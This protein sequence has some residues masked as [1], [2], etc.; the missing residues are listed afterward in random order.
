MTACSSSSTS[1]PLS[2]SNQPA[3]LSGKK[4]DTVGSTTFMRFPQ[5]VEYLFSLPKKLR[6]NKRICLIGPSVIIPKKI[7]ERT[8]IG[9]AKISVSRDFL[10]TITFPQIHELA[11]CFPGNAFHIVD[12][13]AKLIETTQA[14]LGPNPPHQL[15]YPYGFAL[16]ALDQF[17]DQFPKTEALCMQWLQAPKSGQLQQPLIS[18]KGLTFQAADISKEKVNPGK[19]K[20]DF[21]FATKVLLYPASDA[22]DF[23]SDERKIAMERLCQHVFK[24]VKLSGEIFIDQE[25]I[26][27][28]CKAVGIE[29]GA[30]AGF[31]QT[32][33]GLKFSA[34]L[35]TNRPRCED[36]L[37]VNFLTH[38]PEDAVGFA[39][40]TDNIYVFRRMS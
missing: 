36:R 34:K 28:I 38:N 25:S 4:V 17:G 3:L 15:M 21:V 40:Q 33:T 29:E 26:Q 19:K 20:C 37:V 10:D 9:S 12:S 14:T 31:V 23:E 27:K 35:L 5:M 6:E 8:G 24:I 2:P 11:H 22:M 39:I 7:E 18:R 16:N 30:F 13:D 1:S 32:A